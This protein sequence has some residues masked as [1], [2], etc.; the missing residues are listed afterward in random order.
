VS[1]LNL[2]TREG[3]TL[4]VA[5]D[6]AGT[7][8]SYVR[9]VRPQGQITISD[10]RNAVP[11]SDFDTLFDAIIEQVRDGRQVSVS[12]NANLVIDDPGF[13]LARTAYES[14]SDL[15]LQLELTNRGGDASEDV[16]F[17]GG[18]TDFTVTLNESGVATGAF[19]FTASAVVRAS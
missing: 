17:L 15:W 10:S 7:P 19:T 18:F 16:E 14:D 11:V 5:N 13:L 3:V 2:I 6:T 12:W 8:G 9:F 1:V 4:N